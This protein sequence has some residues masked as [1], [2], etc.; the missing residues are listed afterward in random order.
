MFRR[1][2]VNENLDGA[3]SEEDSKTEPEKE[4]P[5][6]S[7]SSM[8]VDEESTTGPGKKVDNDYEK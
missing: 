5:R 3:E 4:K 7:V 1:N 6:N 2:F 8:D